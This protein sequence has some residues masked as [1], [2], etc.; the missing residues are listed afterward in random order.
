[1]PETNHHRSY[2]ASVKDW[3]I[4]NMIEGYLRARQLFKSQRRPAKSHRLPSFATL[5]EL[6]DLI[7]QIKED[8]HLVFRRGNEN[9]RHGNGNHK[10][11]PGVVETAFVD[12]VGL[13]FHKLLTATELRYILEHY[14]HDGAMWEDNY[15]ALQ[16]SLEKI[17]KLFDEGVHRVLDLIHAH[18][19]N[20]LLATFLLENGSWA[21]QCLGMPRAQFLKQFIN[22]DSDEQ[23]YVRVADYYVQSGWYDKAEEVLQKVL[24]TNPKNAAARQ[25][26]E[27]VGGQ[28]NLR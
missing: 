26:L 19:D 12:N 25:T 20:I 14:A 15:A 3:K 2:L 17:D 9:K 21:S 23:V 24:K 5:K 1:M 8:H 13:L 28:K 7:Y 18:S 10:F 27:R 22:G 11:V 4:R 16:D 6:G